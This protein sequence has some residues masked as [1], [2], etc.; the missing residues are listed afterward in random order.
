MLTNH[1]EWTKGKC[2]SNNYGTID[3]LIINKI[4]MDNVKLKQQNISTAWIDYKKAFDSVP[5]DWIIETLNIHKFDSITTMFISNT[6][7]TGKRISITKMVK[8]KPIIF[9]SILVS[10]KETAHQVYSSSYRYF[11]SL[12]YWTQKINRKGDIFHISCSWM[13][14]NS[15]LQTTINLHQW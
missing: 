14:L 11:H 9:Q 3:R 10:S 4:M 12:G 15:L 1:T 6:M 2:E 7:N 8:L 5:H 13:I